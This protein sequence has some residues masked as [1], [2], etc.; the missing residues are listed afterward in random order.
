MGPFV[1]DYKDM[2]KHLPVN[3]AFMWLCILHFVGNPT[4]R[5]NGIQG[6]V[7]SQVT[8]ENQRQYDTFYLTSTHRK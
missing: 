1:I 8:T 4:F 7:Y 6:L 5:E 2:A 3:S